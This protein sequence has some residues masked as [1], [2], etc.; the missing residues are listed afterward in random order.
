MV[1]EAGIPARCESQAG[2]GAIKRWQR[3]G[4]KNYDSSSM[5][6]E[7]SR[8][9]GFLGFLAI[10][11]GCRAFF[12]VT[13]CTERGHGAHRENKRG[14]S[15]NSV[16]ALCALCDFGFASL[17]GKTAIQSGGEPILV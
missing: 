15:V 8:F 10:F 11:N 17:P 1:S 6:R 5:Q 9:L 7:K 4:I 16:S 2:M 3:Q 12:L 14:A 13:E